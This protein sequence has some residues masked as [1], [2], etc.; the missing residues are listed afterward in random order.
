MTCRRPGAVEPPCPPASRLVVGKGDPGAGRTLSVS[1]REHVGVAVGQSIDGPVRQVPG[2][3]GHT[4]YIRDHFGDLLAA[5]I[6]RV[7]RCSCGPD[8]SCYG[9][10]RSYRNQRDHDRLV[11]Q[12]AIDTLAAEVGR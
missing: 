5:A 10:L 9:C 11:R 2:G 8:T 4:F 12:A 1:R 6:D 3:A 7:G